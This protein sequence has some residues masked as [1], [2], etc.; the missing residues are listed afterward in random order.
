MNY[1]IYFTSLIL[2]LLL[3]LLL[4]YTLTY[5]YVGKYKKRKR[6]LNVYISQTHIQLHTDKKERKK[7]TPVLLLYLHEKIN[8]D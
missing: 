1:F 5:E 6:K 4:F 3:L 2:L 8:K 7:H